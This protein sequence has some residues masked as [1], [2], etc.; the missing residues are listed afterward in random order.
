MR[1]IMLVNYSHKII[2]FYLH[3][4]F[5]YIFDFFNLIKKNYLF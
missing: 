1:I 3:I 4:Y 2:N 5:M